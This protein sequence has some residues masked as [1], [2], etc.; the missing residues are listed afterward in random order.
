MTFKE[1]TR[2]HGLYLCG[3][4]L[5]KLAKNHGNGLTRQQIHYYFQAFNLSTRAKKVKNKIVFNGETY[6]ESKDGYYRKTN[7]DRSL[8]SRNAWEYYFGALEK[9]C[10]IHFIDGDKTNYA[11]E[12][13]EKL[14]RSEMVKKYCV[15]NNQHT[16]GEKHRTIVDAK[17]CCCCGAIIP[18]KYSPA[19]YVQRNFCSM[20]CMHNFRAQTKTTI[21]DRRRKCLAITNRN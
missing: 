12:N 3:M 2:L 20:S 4:S 5:A 15:F 18:R 7:G 19:N 1:I 13:L 6:T 21:G 9:D 8:L 17:S 14:T 16:K 10:D 11:P